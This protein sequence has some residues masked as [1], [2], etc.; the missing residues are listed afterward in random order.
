MVRGESFDHVGLNGPGPEVLAQYLIKAMESTPG[1]SQERILAQFNQEYGPRTAS[2]VATL[3]S[4]TAG[5]PTRLEIMGK[6]VPGMVS[7]EL[8]RM[9]GLI[10]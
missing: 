6:D 7:A 3:D 5:G 4:I 1:V 2:D 8:L 10:E 9:N